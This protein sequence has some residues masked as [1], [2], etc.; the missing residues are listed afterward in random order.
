MTATSLDTWSTHSVVVKCNVYHYILL[1]VHI[2]SDLGVFI[3]E[4]DENGFA[5]KSGKLQYNDRVLACN[6]VDFTKEHTTQQV[7]DN[8]YRMAQEPLLRMAISRG[9]NLPE[10][11]DNKTSADTSGESHVTSKEREG[12]KVTVTASS[13]STSA[14]AS[15][16][17]ASVGVGGVSGNGSTRGESAADPPNSPR[18]CKRERESKYRV[19]ALD[20]HIISSCTYVT[21]PRLHH[22]LN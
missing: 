22:V 3:G 2:R 11:E 17:G 16:G 21:S 14:S 1:V 4:M 15:V 10:A 20:K 6:G 13:A 7:K 8:F 12:E 5:F 19:I 18:I 9:V